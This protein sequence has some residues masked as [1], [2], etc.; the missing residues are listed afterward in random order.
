[1]TGENSLYVR[2]GGEAAVAAAV[3]IFYRKVLADDRVSGFFEDTDMDKQIAKQKSFLTM[4][5][6]GPN[7]YTGKDLRTAHRPLVEKGMDDSHFD[8]V[9]QHLKATLEQLE[10]PG[11]LVRHVTDLA[12]TTRADVLTRDSQKTAAKVL[13]GCRRFRCSPAASARL[14]SPRLNLGGRQPERPLAC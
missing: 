3:N 10:V 12:E 6:G 7:N 8:A 14:I 1:M 13:H 2:I 4:V 5:F 9:L 11:D